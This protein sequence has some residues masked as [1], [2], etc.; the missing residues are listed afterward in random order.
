MA[1]I[2]VVDDRSSNRHYLR[3]VLAGVGHDVIEAADGALALARTREL[4]PDL[5]IT[6]LLMPVMDG[7]EFV[8]KMRT[9]PEIAAT[10]VIFYTATYRS[11][12]A[13]KLATACGVTE[14]LPKPTGP[15]LLIDTVNRVLGSNATLPSDIE[16][17][18]E[19]PSALSGLGQRMAGHID[20]VTEDQEL[21]N[22]V[23]REHSGP[24]HER[25]RLRRLSLR[26]ADNVGHVQ[27]SASRIFALIELA[28][29]LAVERRRDAFLR[30]FC[31]ASR[32]IVE[33]DAVALVLLRADERGVRHV[34]AH[35]LLPP[36]IESL[37]GPA[38]R[39]GLIGRVWGRD[40]ALRE[41]DGGDLLAGLPPS[42]GPVRSFLG[43]PVGSD[44]A[45]YG[46]LLFTDERAGHRFDDEDE[47]MALAL[48]GEFVVMF[49]LFDANETLQSRAVELELQIAQRQHAEQ[50]QA[51]ALARLDGM[52]N[53]AM[54]AIITVDRSHRV[55]LFNPAAERMF[56]RRAADMMGHPLDEL[57]PEAARA[58]HADHLRAFATS[59]PST[60]T[61]SPSRTVR[62]RRANG[63]TFPIDASISRVVL[64]S[65]VY[66]TAILRDVTQRVQANQALE[67]YR[68]E[69]AGFSQRLL[70]Q[71]KQ[72]TRRLAQALHD[73][74]GQTLAAMRLIYDA[75]N[76]RA[77]TAPNG[78]MRRLDG[79]ITEANQQVRQVLVDLRPPLLD[80]LGLAAALD[81]ELRQRAT[82]T[83]GVELQLDV[84]AG[85]QSLRWKPEAEYAAFMIAREAVQNALRHA[86]PATIRVRLTGDGTGLTLAV[87]D[88]GCGLP[89]GGALA[90]PGH[91][92]MV[93]M[94][95][96][97]LAIGAVL[98]IQSA[99]GQGT[100]V[101]LRWR[102]SNDLERRVPSI[103]G[104]VSH[105]S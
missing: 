97:A 105:A 35:G 86:R 52:I 6:D 73:E 71:E 62:G 3:V 41:G 69:L 15:R 68:V 12:E 79:L 9:E 77:D 21:I 83:D 96:R 65:G 16:A 14:V 70:E 84:A 72:T 1:R 42:F 60:R 85:L 44:S 27:R 25:E 51:E 63:E 100:T 22:G 58:P 56:G 32:R 99:P 90:A 2:L 87:S 89:I 11:T 76:G 20:H 61:M 31:D 36:A 55:V 88:D 95:E 19:A 48:A 59:G 92:G 10:P 29:D 39:Q 26:L 33:A 102:E 23:L 37:Y 67:Q 45:Q 7:F 13:H 4:R 98:D 17:A 5:V 103:D 8:S 34:E 30:M 40:A 101:H 93:G 78:L 75:C 47:M 50:A 53:A 64:D 81:N 82:L 57:L 74:L 66:F 94:R 54:D 43:V 104:M 18:R 49:E 24:E 46:V 80:E 38:I 91:L 28:L